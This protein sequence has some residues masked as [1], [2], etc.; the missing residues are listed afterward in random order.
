MVRFIVKPKNDIHSLKNDLEAIVNAKL[1][2]IKFTFSGYSILQGEIPNETYEKIFNTKLDYEPIS[3]GR[4][5]LYEKTKPY[6]TDQSIENKI[7]YVKVIRS[8]T[9]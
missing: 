7:D 8:I 1:K 5:M 9:T 4:K 6:I 2:I 3:E